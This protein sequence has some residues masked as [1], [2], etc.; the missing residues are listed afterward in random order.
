VV[1]VSF[2]DFSITYLPALGLL[3]HMCWQPVETGPALSVGYSMAGKLPYTIEEASKVGA[4]LGGDILVETEATIKKVLN[5]SR[6]ASIIHLAAHGTFRHDNPLFSGVR[7]A[8]GWLTTFEWFHQQLDA[9]LITFSACNTGRSVIAGGD[10]LLGLARACI[11]AGASTLLMSQWAVDDQTTADLVG[12]FYQSLTSGVHPSKAL[13][14]ACVALIEG[15]SVPNA[16]REH[17]HPYFWA[18]FFLIGAIGNSP[19]Q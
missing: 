15:N 5:A 3:P 19:Y 18:P 16:I 4:L 11:A 13:Q 17:A 10:E 7:L 1:A 14:G 6:N 2:E 8:D 12:C 9:R